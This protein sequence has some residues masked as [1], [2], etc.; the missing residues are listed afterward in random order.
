M[1][2]TNR[3]A[4]HPE[5]V[6]LRTHLERERLRGV[7]PWDREPRRAEDERVHEHEQ[8]RR[9]AVLCRLLRVVLEQPRECARENE[10]DALADGA[11]PETDAP[12][13]A[14]DRRHREERTQHVRNLYA[15]GMSACGTGEKQ[16]T[17]GVWE[18]RVPR[19]WVGA[20]RRKSDSEAKEEGKEGCSHR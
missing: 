1:A 5:R 6:P 4:E 9:A 16:G 11:P 2:R 10:R 15:R 8:R 17:R 20:W 18:G 12:A 14:V 13:E 3:P 7:H 19:R